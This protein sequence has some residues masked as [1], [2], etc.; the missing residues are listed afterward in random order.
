MEKEP[1]VIWGGHCPCHRTENAFCKPP[2]T[3]SFSVGASATFDTCQRHFSPGLYGSALLVLFLP[4]KQFVSLS[5]SSLFSVTVGCVP[6]RHLGYHS[7]LQ[8]PLPASSLLYC[9]LKIHKIQC[10]RLH[11]DFATVPMQ[12]P[13]AAS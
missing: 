6:H 4:R 13:L 11:F 2:G 5:F 12:N 7:G 8:T 3:A 1:E 9:G 10:L